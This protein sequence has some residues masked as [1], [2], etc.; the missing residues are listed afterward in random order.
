MRMRPPAFWCFQCSACDT[1][2]F[3][4]IP[5]HSDANGPNSF[6]TEDELSVTDLDFVSRGSVMDAPFHFCLV[7]SRSQI[8]RKLT[9]QLRSHLQRR[10]TGV[11]EDLR[12]E[13]VR[14]QHIRLLCGDRGLPGECGSG[15][16][17]RQQNRREQNAL[18]QN[19]NFC[20]YQRIDEPEHDS[21]LRLSETGFDQSVTAVHPANRGGGAAKNGHADFIRVYIKPFP[22]MEKPACPPVCCIMRSASEATDTSP[23]GMFMGKL[24]CGSRRRGSRWDVRRAA[25]MHASVALRCGL[26]QTCSAAATSSMD[27]GP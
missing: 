2:R 8:V 19:L 13:A 24:S 20:R 9:A 3:M 11:V 5:P 10:D 18:L 4:P 26:A 15:Q 6:T 1:Q 25:G 7:A 23:R 27:T 22:D 16:R 21:L 14:A 17:E 12:G